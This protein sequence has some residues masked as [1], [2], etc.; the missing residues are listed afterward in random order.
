[1]RKVTWTA[2]GVFARVS[3]DQDRF[4]E[5][6]LQPNCTPHTAIPGSLEGY[7][8][9][10]PKYDSRH[11]VLRR[12]RDRCRYFFSKRRGGLRVYVW[13]ATW[14]RSSGCAGAWVC[15][16]NVWKS[17]HAG[18]TAQVPALQ[19]KI[20]AGWTRASQQGLPDDMGIV[21]AKLLVWWA[22]AACH[23]REALPF[24]REF[25]DRID[26][27]IRVRVLVDT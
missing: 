14:G 25:P 17:G 24:W 6:G 2:A 21:L 15:L 13:H 26:M 10:T 19:L 23:R 7:I 5:S 12:L 4:R 16:W 1:M 18:F 11:Q 8:A 9:Y 27:T 22:E 20:H 3:A